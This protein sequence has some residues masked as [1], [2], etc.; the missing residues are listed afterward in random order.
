M[1]KSLGVILAGAAIALIELPYLYKQK[2]KKETVMFL[3]L[4]LLGTSL[5]LAKVQGAIL[6]NPLDWIA[7]FYKPVNKL[8]NSLFFSR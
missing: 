7:Y 2:L 4:L 5:V 8:I 1:L 6:P 3:I